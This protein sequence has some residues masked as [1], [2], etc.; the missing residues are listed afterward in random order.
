MSSKRFN[1]KL[2]N[3]TFVT[4]YERSWHNEVN[5]DDSLRLLKLRRNNLSRLDTLIHRP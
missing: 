4:T 3:G 2:T 5:L 1:C